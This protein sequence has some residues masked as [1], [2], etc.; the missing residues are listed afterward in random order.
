MNA[1]TELKQIYYS[2]NSN[3]PF[4][5]IKSKQL[6]YAKVNFHYWKVKSVFLH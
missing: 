6:E 4:L 1:E 3:F 2:M 5:L